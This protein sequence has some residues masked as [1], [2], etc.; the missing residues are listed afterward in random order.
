MFDTIQPPTD[1]SMFAE[2]VRHMLAQLQHPYDTIH[3]MAA[4]VLEAG[5]PKLKLA[6]THRFL[7]LRLADALHKIPR[8]M[9]EDKLDDLRH[10]VAEATVAL[11]EL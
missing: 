5:I 8:S 11:D 10:H 3:T 4:E 1:D 7:V 6:A 9:R 2:K